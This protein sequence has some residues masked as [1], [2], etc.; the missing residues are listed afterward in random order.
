MKKIAIFCGGPSSEYEVSL[1]SAKAILENIDRKKYIPY[2]FYIQKNS[3]S[4]FYKARKT[5]DPPKKTVFNDFE[6]VLKENKNNFDLALLSALH[7]EFGED[8]TIQLLLENLGIK[9]TGSNSKSSQLCINK[10]KAN[11]KVKKIK[12]IEVPITIHVNIKGLGKK[13][14]LKF[15]FI[16]KPNMLGSSV[17]VFIVNNQKEYESSIKK[18]RGRNVEDLLLQELIKG[19]EFSCGC[20]EKKNGNFIQ[21]PPI[22]IIPKAN[23]FDYKSKYEVGASDE[24]TPPVSIS[25]K[26]ADRI[27]NI[28]VKIHKLLKC[29][30]FSRSDFIYKKGNLYFLETNT[31]P[32]MTATSLLPKEAAAA[33]ISFTKLI[34]F[35]IEETK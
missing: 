9:Y 34:N 13:P 5:I 15:P 22:E 30:T 16:I 6:I 28:T 20:L 24:V 1:N 17:L 33:G 8:G 21:L 7:G 3:K 19:I 23:F 29:A 25:K 18:I 32:G 11:E 10:M 2:I 12:N 27:S 4:A 35:L 26:E 31:L 14:P